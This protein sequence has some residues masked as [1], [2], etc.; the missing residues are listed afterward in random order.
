MIG[1]GAYDLT[2]NFITPESYAKEVASNIV[3]TVTPFSTKVTDDGSVDLK[4]PFVPFLGILPYDISTNTDWAGKSI[5]KESPYNPY[6]PA[7]E[8]GKKNVNPILKEGAQ[9][10]NKLAGGDKV[11][12]SGYLTD[13]NPSKIQHSLEFIFSGSGK[14]ALQMSKLVSTP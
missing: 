9:E 5:Y 3:Q 14:F 4:R 12:S 2:Q 1:A 13:W 7:S 11:R 8:L 6:A 10:L